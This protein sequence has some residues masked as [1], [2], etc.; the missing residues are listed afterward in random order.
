MPVRVCPRGCEYVEL[1]RRDLLTRTRLSGRVRTHTVFSFETTNCPRCGVQLA[2]DCPRCEKKIL[3]PVEDRCQFCGLPQPWAQERRAGVERASIRRWRP[4]EKGAHDPAEPLY[5]GD[6]GDLW[7]LEGDIA[8]LDVDAVISNDDVDGQMWAEVARAIKTAAGDEVEQRAQDETPYALG[9]AWKTTAGDLQMEGIIHV[10]SMGRRGEQDLDVV[11]DCLIAA[12]NLATKEGFRSI[13]TAAFG[14]GPR[15]I[16]LSEWLSEF[17]HTMVEYLSAP[18][19]SDGKAVPELSVVLVLFE[20]D[21]FG[22]A[23]TTLRGAVCD[24][25]NE[26]GRKGAPAFPCAG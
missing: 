24:A 9:Q 23:L 20:P 22:R 6:R 3:A 25:W 4:G 19:I 17:A 10:A 8:R 13:G 14:S 5:R 2:E 11:R 1:A 7:V 12:L 15:A 26:V 21:G 16:D 18:A